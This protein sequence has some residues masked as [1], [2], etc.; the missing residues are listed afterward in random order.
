LRAQSARFI[1]S[2]DADQSNRD[3]GGK[4]M[5]GAN[6]WE[7][8]LNERLIA[9]DPIAP[10]ELVEQLLDTIV[11]E[12]KARFP[13][14]PDEDFHTDA[15]IEAFAAY[16]KNP[17]QF[18]PELRSLK[19]FLVMAADGDFRNMLAKRRTL[20]VHETSVENVEVFE[21]ARNM[22]TESQNSANQPEP[23]DELISREGSVEYDQFLNKNF[24]DSLD[25]QM[26]D[27]ILGNERSTEQFAKIL[28][29]EDR[30]SDVQQRV[31]KQHKDRIKK[32]LMRLRKQ[33]HESE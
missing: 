16:I 33:D 11:L 3:T 31:V 17:Q 27:M 9:G 25:R 7:R 23:L 10:V 1:L 21:E 14:E 30:P 18:D 29:I 28:G 26:A 24:P 19:G 20:R 5:P 15:T 13:R 12:L 22:H 6:E 2:R 4:K 8:R 32:R